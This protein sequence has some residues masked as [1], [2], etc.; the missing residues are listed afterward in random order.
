MSDLEIHYSKAHEDKCCMISHMQAKML[1]SHKHRVEGQ[2]SRLVVAW[3][4][5]GQ[6]MHFQLDRIV[7]SRNPLFNMVIK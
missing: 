1:K 2:L 3:E 7:S 4:I 5:F 6:R